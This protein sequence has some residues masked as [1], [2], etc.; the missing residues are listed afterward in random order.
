MMKYFS[1][2][3]II[4]ILF[5]L[6]SCTSENKFDV[7][8]SKIPSPEIKIKRYEK[9]IFA[10]PPEEFIAQLPKYQEEFPLFISGDLQ[11]TNSL[12]QL[13]SFFVDPHMIE[14]NNLVQ[15][16]F[17]N[18]SHQEAHLDEAFRH[19]NY[20]IPELPIPTIYS[21]VSGL[22]FK[23]PIKYANENMLIALDMYLG[24]ETNAY[25]ISGFPK[26]RNHW[27]IKEAIVGDAMAEL[28]TGL[29][30]EKNPS[31]N[32][33]DQMIYEGKKIY[34]VKC[35]I[36]DIADSLL[37]KYTS[38]QLKW[39]NEYEGN[40]WSYIVEN[41]LL[42]DKSKQVLRKFFEDGPFTDLFAKASPPRL[43]AFLGWKIIKGYMAEND[44]DLKQM[45]TED[46]AQKILKLS[47]YKP[48][49]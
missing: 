4:N 18:L 15:K 38:S 8:I 17:P 1:K 44:F 41:Q 47:L 29:L 30:P 36:P 31:D 34:F 25:Q 7:D 11:D 22:D 33:L 23:F 13:K 37:F 35:M 39:I 40:V 24:K 32:L 45:M 43:G 27:S 10:I 14:L 49:L 42:Y 12:L 21:Y 6:F 20:Y 19:L 16:N 26:Y 5:L 9:A 48:K 2:I 3:L 28:A 46:N